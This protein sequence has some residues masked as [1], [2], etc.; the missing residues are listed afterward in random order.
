LG[1]VAS[2]STLAA[3]SPAASFGRSAAGSDLPP[4][5]LETAIGPRAGASVARSAGLRGPAGATPRTQDEAETPLRRKANPKGTP[6]GRGRNASSP[7]SEPEG[8]AS[9]AEECRGENRRVP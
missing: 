6:A 4:R 8:F 3:D 1:E 5:F 2:E 9:E 7:Q